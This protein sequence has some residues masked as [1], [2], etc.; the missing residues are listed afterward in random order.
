MGFVFKVVKSGSAIRG[1][2]KNT[3]F[4]IENNWDDYGFKTQFY[5]VVHDQ[6]GVAHDIGS[7]KI[8]YVD[9]V[10]GW[11][12]A[13][14]SGEFPALSNGFFSLGQ[15]AEYYL[16][17]RRVFSGAGIYSFLSSLCD[18]VV[19][20]GGLQVAKQQQVFKESLLRGGSLS[21]I[22]VQYR[23]VV[24]GG[25]LLTD[26]DFRYILPAAQDV[27]GFSLDFSVI[28]SSKP[29]TNMHVLI[30]RNGTGKTTLLN[31][32]V[33]AVLG[34]QSENGGRFSTLSYQ[35]KERSLPSDYFSS[36]ISVS[37]SAFDP[38]IPPPNQP[39]R[40]KGVCYYY[41]GLKQIVGSSPGEF[42]LKTS[43]KLCSDFVESL[44]S[45]FGTANK[46]EQW[47]QAISKL[48][49]DTNF[50]E[51]KLSGLAGMTDAKS[52]RE[53]AGTL[54][55]SLSSGHAIVLL[56]ITKLVETVDEK[57]LVLLDEPE[58]HL[59]PPLLS[60]FTRAL[61]DLLLARNGVSIVAT[62]SP[63]VLQEVPSSCVWKL[64]RSGHEGTQERPTIETFAENVGVLTREIFG[65][66]VSKAGFHDLLA[67]A[68]TTGASYTEIVEEFGGYLG[69]EGKSILMALL[70]N[71]K[72]ERGG[73]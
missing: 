5:L 39:D 21:S 65:L 35:G 72:I 3:A 69:Y 66:E 12:S 58:S 36:V 55:L 49:S 73:I 32:M 62:H 71:R 30:G 64:R 11:T 42:L 57:A 24:D 1:I 26:F 67:E 16:K 43:E 54:F 50:A 19:D 56:T 18:V 37:F 15:E 41:V 52:L 6:S 60:A 63:V 7:L 61:S 4:L 8:G 17:L 23:R 45:F 70:S 29:S 48:E 14:L 53:R 34:Q 13:K 51:T 27:A 40:T 10:I 22:D 20:K 28:E 46:K 59:H 2:H 9:Q 31:G 38:F 47:L 25:N 68:V 33:A 44:E